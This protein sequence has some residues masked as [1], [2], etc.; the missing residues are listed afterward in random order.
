MKVQKKYIVLLSI[1]GILALI[2]I[3]SSFFQ[4][5]VYDVPNLKPVQNV[6]EIE[7]RRGTGTNSIL[8]LTNNKWMLEPGGY[9][10]DQEAADEMIKHL[11][12]FALTDLVS[13]SGV[14]VNYGLDESNR[15]EIIINDGGK[16][17]LHFF[18]GKASATMRHTYVQMPGDKNIYQAKGNFDYAFNKDADSLK[19]REIL[20]LSKEDIIEVEINE[21]GR[22]FV[23]S[24]IE[25]KETDTKTN[26]SVNK[27]IEW[28]SSW[29]N[30]PDTDKVDAFLQKLTP[31]TAA[32]LASGKLDEAAPYL[33]LIRIRT[34]AEE[35]TIYIINQEK[36]KNYIVGVKG[37]PSLF[38]ISEAQGKDLLKNINEL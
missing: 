12:D 3:F 35:L 10:A 15:I 38:K 32:G 9:N 7:L 6:T 31:L 24:R 25:N 21:K 23:L 19:S 2:W 22:K 30:P 26:I 36:D 28:K 27:T 20:K 13:R 14:L 33:R 37:N 18:M 8:I 1:L 29:K 17:V 34:K 16:T 11:K 4:E 5:R